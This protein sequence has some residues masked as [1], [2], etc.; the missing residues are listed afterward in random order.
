MSLSY[1]LVVS[2]EVYGEQSSLNAYQFAEALI[3]KGHRLVSVFFYQ[4]GVTNGNGLTVPANDE[5]DLV[6]AWQQLAAEH[7]VLLQTCV[8]AALR[9]GIVGKE[10]SEQHQLAQSNLA[11]GFEQSGLGSLA[12][13]L[14]T[15][16]RVVQF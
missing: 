8:A 16:D 13:A 11:D 9:R 1:T 3:K 14:L 12:E 7:G 4:Q 2:G 10:E 5:F 15:Q 6:S